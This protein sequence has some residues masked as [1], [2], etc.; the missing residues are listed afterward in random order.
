MIVRAIGPS[1]PIQGKLGDPLLELYDGDGNLIMAN[2]NWNDEQQAQIAATTIPP[3]NDLESAIVE[4]LKPG[5]YTALVR[6]VE[7]STG[8]AVVEIYALD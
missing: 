2:N 3:S 7:D 5:A 8:I 6:G 4:A 1:L